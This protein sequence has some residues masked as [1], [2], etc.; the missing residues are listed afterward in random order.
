[1]DQL[2]DLDMYLDD[3]QENQNS[4]FRKIKNF[5]SQS[6]NSENFFITKA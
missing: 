6:F 2:N 4:I 1:M 3:D 5:D